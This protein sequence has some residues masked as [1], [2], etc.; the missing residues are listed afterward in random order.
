MMIDTIDDLLR[1]VREN[2]EYRAAMQRELLTEA[3]LALPERF[4][5][6]TEVTDRRLGAIET[7]V[8]S[9]HGILSRQQTDF[10]NI[11]GTYAEN[12]ARRNDRPI[13][14]TIAHARGNRVRLTERLGHDE[15]GS[16][17]GEAVNRDLLSG[18]TED[19]EDTFQNPDLALRV[20]E[21]NREQS[22]FYILAQASY[23]GQLNDYTRCRD[24]AT[25]MKRVSGLEAYGVAVGVRIG[26][27]MPDD[28][29]FDANA[30]VSAGEGVLWYQLREPRPEDDE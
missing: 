10:A 18:V 29:L 20:H 9:L 23:T 1:L 8:S 22:S 16:I 13:A 2:D 14:A 6:Y 4:A 15:L 12:E 7:D 3:L 26:R 17:F 25:I 28:L 24:H 19:S 30:L 11:R 21:R 27:N 5:A